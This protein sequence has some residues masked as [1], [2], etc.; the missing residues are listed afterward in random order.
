M[1]APFISYNLIF[2]P[3]SA[4][5]KY[6]APLPGLYVF[7]SDRF[8]IFHLRIPE[9]KLIF[10]YMPAPFISYNQ[11]FASASAPLNYAS[12]PVP[13]HGMFCKILGFDRFSVYVRTD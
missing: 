4:P 13:L 8:R 12:I 11:I 2:A 6:Y 7:R 5:L 1:P 10:P 9:N 3:A